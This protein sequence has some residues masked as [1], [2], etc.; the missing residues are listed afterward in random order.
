MDAAALPACARSHPDRG[1]R[2]RWAKAL[3]GVHRYALP[4]Q[5]VAPRARSHVPGVSAP[6]QA[7]HRV[8][9]KANGAERV[10]PEGMSSGCRRD[11]VACAC[12]VRINRYIPL[13]C[14]D[15]S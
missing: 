7:R 1:T 4:P 3:A 14:M 9:T 13:V 2:R 6:A 5:G 11:V 15:I 10:T 8:K 12:I